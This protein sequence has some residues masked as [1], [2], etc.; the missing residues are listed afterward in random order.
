M[1]N[2]YQGTGPKSAPRP[3]PTILYI[4]GDGTRNPVVQTLVDG[5]VVQEDEFA[6]EEEAVAE[7]GRRRASGFQ[8]CPFC[9]YGKPALAGVAAGAVLATVAGFETTRGAL[10]GGLAGLAYGQFY[11]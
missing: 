4:A 6:T 2:G 11:R 10:W 1:T 3:R 5:E 7:A 9:R 8:D